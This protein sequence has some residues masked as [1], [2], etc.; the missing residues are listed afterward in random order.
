MVKWK[1]TNGE[2]IVAFILASWSGWRRPL[3]ACR[4]RLYR[5]FCGGCPFFSQATFKPLGGVLPAFPCP[6]YASTLP[7]TKTAPGLDAWALK[8]AGG[9]TWKVW[10][11]CPGMNYKN[12][13]AGGTGII[14]R[15]L[16]EFLPGLFPRRRPGVPKL[17]FQSVVPGVCPPIIS[18][19]PLP[20]VFWFPNSW[21][22]R[23]CRLVDNSI[24]PGIV[25]CCDSILINPFWFPP[26][27]KFWV[28]AF[29]KVGIGNANF[30]VCLIKPR[31]NPG[32]NKLPK[33]QA[34]L[35]NLGK[36]FVAFFPT[37]NYKNRYSFLSLPLVSLDFLIDRKPIADKERL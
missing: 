5:K 20:G 17:A 27:F 34:S 24:C 18:G 6:G 31:W 14:C 7:G 26:C 19:Y 37:G 1:T 35:G 2:N 33:P 12:N 30:W 25:R 22:R 4:W 16:L 3:A 36:A 23:P 10:G 21:R 9:F 28:L 13:A 11:G 29:Q 8:I 32:I 15:N